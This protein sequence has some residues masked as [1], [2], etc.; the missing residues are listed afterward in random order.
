MKKMIVV[1]LAFL[2]AGCD[3][4]PTYPTWSPLDLKHDKLFDQPVGPPDR[5]PLPMGWIAT[6]TGWLF[7]DTALHTPATTDNMQGEKP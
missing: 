4:L 3:Q 2:V 1:L 6:D 7:I 5:P